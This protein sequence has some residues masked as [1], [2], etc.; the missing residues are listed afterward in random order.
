MQNKVNTIDRH[1]VRTDSYHLYRAVQP[2]IPAVMVFL[3]FLKYASV[4]HDS[5][6]AE[7]IRGG[8]NE[9]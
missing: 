5:G 1:P 3:K 7:G 8:A 4:N 2:V 9:Y 6:L